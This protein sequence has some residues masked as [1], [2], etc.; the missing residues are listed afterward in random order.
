MCKVLFNFYMLI[1]LKSS[2]DDFIKN[3]WNLNK[4]LFYKKSNVIEKV[5]D[6]ICKYHIIYELNMISYKCFYSLV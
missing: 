1:F 4:M 6:L 3:L 5:I 2:F